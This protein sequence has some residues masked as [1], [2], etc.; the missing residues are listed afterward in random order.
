MQ[1][2]RSIL[3]TWWDV[4]R[5]F[6]KIEQSQFIGPRKGQ[7]E[8]ELHLHGPRS[9]DLDGLCP[10]SAVQDLMGSFVVAEGEVASVWLDKR[11]LLMHLS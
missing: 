1:F 10:D 3:M 11:T 7:D 5:A 9:P 2:I 6:P 4:P 8:R